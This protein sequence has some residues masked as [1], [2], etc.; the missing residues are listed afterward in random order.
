M[1]RAWYI[2]MWE[3]GDGLP[4]DRNEPTRF[5][6]VA[7]FKITKRLPKGGDYCQ[8]IEVILP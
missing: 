4:N 7:N 1:T 3:I 8:A 6:N 5:I 2:P